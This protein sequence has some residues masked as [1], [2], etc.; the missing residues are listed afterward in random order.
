LVAADRAEAIATAA[1]AEYRRETNQQPGW[2]VA[3]LA[4][5]QSDDA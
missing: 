4:F 1:A 5:D 3:T 2:C